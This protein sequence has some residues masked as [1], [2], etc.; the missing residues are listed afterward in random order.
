MKIEITKQE[1]LELTPQFDEAINSLKNVPFKV[2]YALCK[3][4]KA[5]LDADEALKKSLEPKKEW[6]EFNDERIKLAKELCDKDENGKPV[7]D[8]G[9]FKMSVN[10]QKFRES[11]EALKEKYKEAV[12]VYDKDH[13]PSAF[14]EKIEIEVHS[15]LV[16]LV[17]NEKFDGVAVKLIN[18]FVADKPEL[19]VVK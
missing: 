14:K 4:Q 19:Q 17:E 15:I 18:L 13:H 12:E 10:D 8:N 2:S 6:I 9:Q 5:F 16:S 1:L 7:I 11:F 3:N